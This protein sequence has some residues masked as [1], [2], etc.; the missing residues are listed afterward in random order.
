[1]IRDLWAK[2]QWMKSKMSGL[3]S[4]WWA[5]Q[6]AAHHDG[7]SQRHHKEAG[8]EGPAGGSG[9]N[10]GRHPAHWQQE[11]SVSQ[12]VWEMYVNASSPVY[13][14]IMLC[15]PAAC[16][17]CGTSSWWSGSVLVA[18]Q[19]NRINYH[20]S[21]LNWVTWLFDIT[22]KSLVSPLADGFVSRSFLL[23]M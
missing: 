12:P 11:S 7:R 21:C 15:D 18:L 22:V 3:F 17:I 14:F 1:M 4:V 6:G 8:G 5:T 16:V 19:E 10:P 23:S 13:E 20:H 2:M 9:R